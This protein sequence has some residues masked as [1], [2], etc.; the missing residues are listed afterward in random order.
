MGE[1]VMETDVDVDDVG[2]ED[3]V[4]ECDQELECVFKGVCVG[5]DV[6]DGLNVGDTEIESA[7]VAE[8]VHVIVLLGE[9]VCVEEGTVEN[10]SVGVCDIV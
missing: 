8:S 5:V 3:C 6:G 1:K 9:E 2:M 10:E 4:I 7:R